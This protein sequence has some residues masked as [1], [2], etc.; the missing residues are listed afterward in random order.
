MSETCPPLIGQRFE[1]EGSRNHTGV[2][3]VLNVDL[4]QLL[5]EYI[6]Y[7]PTFMILS[8]KGASPWF[9]IECFLSFKCILVALLYRITCP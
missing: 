8:L 1:S 9:H 6:N 5:P 7:N 2:K 3:K 4:R